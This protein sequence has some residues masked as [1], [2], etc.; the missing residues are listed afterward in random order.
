MNYPTHGRLY[1]DVLLA[2]YNYAPRP[3]VPVGTYPAPVPIGTRPVG[4]PKD[5]TP[6]SEEWERFVD[7][8]NDP[9]AGDAIDKPPFGW[10]NR[11]NNPDS[12]S[13]AHNTVKIVGEGN[14][15]W[16]LEKMSSLDSPPD[17][18]DVNFYNT[19]WLASLM[20]AVTPS[21]RSV[22]CGD[23]KYAFSLMVG[24]SPEWYL[25]K[26]RV[27]V[28]PDLP[29]LVNPRFDLNI[30]SYPHL[31]GTYNIVDVLRAGTNIYVEEYAIRGAMVWGRIGTDEWI[32]LQGNS[33]TFYTS[34]KLQSPGLPLVYPNPPAV[35]TYPNVR[36]QD[37]INAIYLGSLATDPWTE[38]IAPAGLE[39]L[40]VPKTNRSKLYYGPPIENIST[41]APAEVI[42]VKGQLRQYLI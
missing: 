24:K 15:T 4:E 29:V 22:L 7:Q 27:E 42:A 5:D 23:N 10:R 32:A 31:H 30:R 21:G 6:L 33:G 40:A 20:T 8:V 26:D 19:P 34:W 16:Q 12:L 18:R 13:F 14:G 11:N 39:Y 28:F 36:N 35:Q 1:P 38:T 41:L 37:I 9:A 17:W 3:I 2:M 25:K